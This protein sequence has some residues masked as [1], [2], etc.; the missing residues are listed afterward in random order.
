MATKKYKIKISYKTNLVQE[1][2]QTP[3]KYTQ[4]N[5]TKKEYRNGCWENR[6]KYSIKKFLYKNKNKQH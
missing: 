5:D 6:K 3:L 2:E 1:Q 4:V